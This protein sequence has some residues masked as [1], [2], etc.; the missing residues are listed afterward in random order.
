MKKL[1]TILFL[2]SLTILFFSCESN[3][4]DYLG[5]WICTDKTLYAGGAPIQM[6]NPE[7]YYIVI[8][9]KSDNYYFVEQHG[10]GFAKGIFELTKEGSL[11]TS[12][13]LTS[14][15]IIFDHDRKS[16]VMDMYG[17]IYHFTKKEE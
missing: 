1:F 8:S 6:Q 9:K 3:S 14:T 11:K 7:N 13:A 5:K 15:T 12:D 16:I 2:S 4:N 17:N 10:Y